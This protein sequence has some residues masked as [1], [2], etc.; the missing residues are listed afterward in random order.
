MS[1]ARQH[2]IT[3]A[4]HLVGSHYL[5]GAAGNHPN[6]SD[7]VFYSRNAAFLAHTSLSP[8]EP[9][10]FTAQCETGGHYV[11]AGRPD[12]CPGARPC[13]PHDHDLIEY[14]DHLRDLSPEFWDPFASNFTPRRCISDEGDAWHN[15]LLWGEDCRFRRHFDCIHFINYVI[16]KTTK[17]DVRLNIQSWIGPASGYT[18]KKPMDAPPLPGDILAKGSHHIGFLDENGYVLQA[19]DHATGVHNDEKYVPPANPPRPGQWT[20]RVRLKDSVLLF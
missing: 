19:Q 18:D 15:Q 4:R 7:G 11:C 13:D 2:I 20:D 9:C 16:S 10:V 5:W 1:D 12:K 17:L 14:L 3:Y 6:H 8:S